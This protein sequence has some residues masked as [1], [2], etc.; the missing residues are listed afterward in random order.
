MQAAHTSL[1]NGLLR[2]L[3]MWGEE[4]PSGRQWHADLIR[5]AGRPVGNRPAI[6]E[7]QVVGAADETRQF[8]NVAVRSY[9]NF[10]QARA[11][12]AVSAAQVLVIELQPAIARFRQAI[13]P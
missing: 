2:I 7:G 8:R 13:D 11:A 1:E 4:A 5:R 12:P 6:L 9:E 3:E 10:D